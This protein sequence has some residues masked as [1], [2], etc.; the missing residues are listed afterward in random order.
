MGNSALDALLDC[1]RRCTPAKGEKLN[2][3]SIPSPTLR[4]ELSLIA[5]GLGKYC[6]EI[7]GHCRGLLRRPRTSRLRSDPVVGRSV[8]LLRFVVGLSQLCDI[9]SFHWT[10]ILTIS[11]TS[12]LA[13]VFRDNSHC[14]DIYFLS[15]LASVRI[16]PSEHAP[17]RTR[18]TIPPSRDGVQHSSGTYSR[19]HREA[20]HRSTAPSEACSCTSLWR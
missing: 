10:F 1:G 2:Q 8:M 15:V 3:S 19:A 11:G 4:H 7:C 5:G 14:T 17:L 20:P 16:R 12:T 18:S 9:C 6:K 13:I